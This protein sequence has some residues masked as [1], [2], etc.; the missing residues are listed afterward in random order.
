MTTTAT[1]KTTTTNHNHDRVYINDDEHRRLGC[2][3]TS[4]PYSSG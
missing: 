4:S 3:A 1:R 2:K